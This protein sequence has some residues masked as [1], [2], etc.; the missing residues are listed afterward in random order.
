MIYTVEFYEEE[1]DGSPG[2]FRA[3]NVDVDAM[4]EKQIPFILRSRGE[5]PSSIKKIYPYNNHT[6][7]KE[8]HK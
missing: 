1:R 2:R 3:V 7:R 8:S 6:E 5:R 4:D